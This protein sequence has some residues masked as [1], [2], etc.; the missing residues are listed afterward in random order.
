M[1][2]SGPWCAALPIHNRCRAALC[3]TGLSVALGVSQAAAR[4]V[5]HCARVVKQTISWPCAQI[6]DQLWTALV[7]SVVGYAALFGI[8]YF[9]AGVFLC[10]PLLL[11]LWLFRKAVKATFAGAMETLPLHA[12]A[13][14]DRADQVR[15][16]RDCH[17]VAVSLSSSH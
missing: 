16:P 17:L 3:S 13:D 15:T 2:C 4:C 11:I 14:L 5:T 8:K 12:A 10:L 1:E 9:T 7:V 6:F